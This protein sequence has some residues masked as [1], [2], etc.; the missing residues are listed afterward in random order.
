M[1]F[2]P[3]SASSKAFQTECRD[4]LPDRILKYTTAQLALWP[5]GCL[6]LLLYLHC[7]GAPAANP[8]AVVT[9]ILQ[10]S[11]VFTKIR[12]ETPLEVVS[13]WVTV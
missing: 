3:N 11:D 7:A 13:F 8:N 10:P 6:A 9:T 12:S 1:F 4:T 5:Y 2:G